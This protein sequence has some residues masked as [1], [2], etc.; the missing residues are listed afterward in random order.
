MRVIGL[1]E[2]DTLGIDVENASSV[3]LGDCRNGSSG[4]TV[5]EKYY[6][7]ATI[8]ATSGLVKLTGYR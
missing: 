6:R 8:L 4:C 3:L 5:S 7:Q 1:D 2:L